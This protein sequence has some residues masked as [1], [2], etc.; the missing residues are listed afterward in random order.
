MS[1]SAA[2]AMTVPGGKMAEAPAAY[3][4][5][6][7][8]GGIDA[9]DDDH[10]V[11]AAEAPSSRLELGHERQVAGGERGHADDVDVVLDRLPRRLAGRREQRPD[12]DVEAEIGEGRGDHLLAAVVAVLAHL[13]DQDARPAPVVALERLDR[14]RH[15]LDRRRLVRPPACRRPRSP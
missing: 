10:D 6:K 8:C 4:A 15:P 14:A 9:A 1:F 5:S 2:S 3:S 11:G 12:V 7:S 13:G